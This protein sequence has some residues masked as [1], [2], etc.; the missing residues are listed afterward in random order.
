MANFSTLFPN[1]NSGLD[2]TSGSA[3]GTATQIYGWAQADDTSVIPLNKLPSLTLGHTHTYTTTATTHP[4]ALAALV[5]AF[6]NAGQVNAGITV[7]VGT[8]FDAGDILILT[9]GSSEFESYLYT[10]SQKTAGA[11]AAGDSLVSGDFVDITNAGD[12]VTTLTGG[13][14]LNTTGNLTEGNVTVNLDASIA[15][16]TN[17][18]TTA[19]TNLILG[20]AGA[21]LNIDSS[22]FDVDATSVDITSTGNAVLAAG[23][24][25]LATLS[26]GTGAGAEVR[27]TS[28]GTGASAVHVNSSGGVNID[29]S[30]DVDITAAHFDVAT[31]GLLQLS[32]N[33]ATGTAIDI[34][35]TQAAGTININAV[36]STGVGSIALNSGAGELRVAGENIGTTG[37]TAAPLVLAV[38][39]NGQLTTANVTTGGGAQTVNLL[40]DADSQSITS[41]AVNVIPTLATTG[42]SFAV[43]GGLAIGSYFKIVNNP[44]NVTNQATIVLNGS[45]TFLGASATPGSLVLNDNTANF[46]VIKIA[47]GT[48]ANTWAIITS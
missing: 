41:N 35:A 1:L 26:A 22:T 34:D 24:N 33:I 8:V 12:G 27:I 36:G 13:T 43:A 4:A 32:S 44:A 2:F 15:G 23:N 45:E 20:N 37:T 16:I 5:S 7:A 11:G 46:E 3:T 38:A 40:T 30:G 42:R 39:E 28:Q 21:T 31:S 47:A 14:N 48:G 9:N 6:G 29:A 25:S 19:A 10:G 18:N 17:I